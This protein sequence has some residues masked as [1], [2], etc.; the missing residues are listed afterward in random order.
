LNSLPKPGIVKEKLV[1]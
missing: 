1:I